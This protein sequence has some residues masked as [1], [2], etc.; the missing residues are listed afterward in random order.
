VELAAAATIWAMFSCFLLFPLFG[1]P[2]RLQHA[3]MTLL[4]AEVVMLLTWGFASEGC[5]ERP[6]SAVAEAARTAAA[7]DVPLLALALV[8]IAVLRG[9]RTHRRGRRVH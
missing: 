2:V 8:I 4:V 1:L 9:L 7:L 3:A 5:L 6:C